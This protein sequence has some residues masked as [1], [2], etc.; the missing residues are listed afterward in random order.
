MAE[1]LPIAKVASST[2]FSTCPKLGAASS[3]YS[4]STF[5]SPMTTTS[6]VI[7]SSSPRCRERFCGCHVQVALALIPVPL[8]AIRIHWLPQSTLLDRDHFYPLLSEGR[9]IPIRGT[10]VGDQTLDTLYWSLT[11]GGYLAELGVICEYDNLPCRGH[12]V[13]VALYLGYIVG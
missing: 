7:R 10:R 11:H 4:R 13:S 5:N 12:D 2:S 3:P 1:D 6:K 9:Y 8:L